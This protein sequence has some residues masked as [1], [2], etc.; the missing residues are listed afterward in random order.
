MHSSSTAAN[1]FVL[2]TERLEQ[3]AVRYMVTGSVAGMLYGEPRLTHDVDV[4]LELAT[5]AQ[6]E[7]LVAAFPDEE[8]YCA[9]LE[10][11]LIEARRAQRGHFNIIHHETGFKADIYLAGSEAL[12]H[13]A[14]QQRRVLEV[15]GTRLQVAPPEYVIVRKLE[16]HRE[17]GSIKHLDDIRGMLR[18]SGE[19]ID[20]DA[21]EEMITARGLQAEWSAVEQTP[22]WLAVRQPLPRRGPPRG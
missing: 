20:R 11:V 21:L 16:Y 19:E 8:F 15:E 12:H 3:M 18:V 22:P 5:D 6:A 4:V 13:Q 7:A 9:P 10:V 14:L 2:F 17:G 1:L